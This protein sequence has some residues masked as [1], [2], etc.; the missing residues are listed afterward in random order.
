MSK[1]CL[2]FSFSDRF[3]SISSSANA[4]VKRILASVLDNAAGTRINGAHRESWL[5]SYQWSMPR[6]R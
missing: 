4:N 1:S 2:S 5:D 3:A 6:T